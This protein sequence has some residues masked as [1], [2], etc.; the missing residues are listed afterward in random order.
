MQ[1]ASGV[2]AVIS[3]L[4]P[5]W[6]RTTCYLGDSTQERKPKGNHPKAHASNAGPRALQC[7]TRTPQGPLKQPI[8]RALS[9]IGSRAEATWEQPLGPRP[10]A[11]QVISDWR[12]APQF[13]GGARC[14]ADLAWVLAAG[15]MARAL[16]WLWG[17]RARKAHLFAAWY[18]PCFSTFQQKTATRKAAILVG[19]RTKGADDLFPPPFAHPPELKAWGRQDESSGDG[20]L[21]ALGV[22]S[23]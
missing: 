17:E 6:R 12:C 4:E 3:R 16:G 7:R 8:L 13:A 9:C 11:V 20:K 18:T 10:L 15:Y 21:S 14:S 1:P 5:R 23:L 19:P 2:N 22:R